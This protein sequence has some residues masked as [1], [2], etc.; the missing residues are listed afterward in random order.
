[1]WEAL[2]LHQRLSLEPKCSS[3]RLILMRGSIMAGSR[4]RWKWIPHFV[5]MARTELA[6]V[7]ICFP[8][9][10]M[11]LITNCHM[12]NWKFDFIQVSNILCPQL[13]FFHL[14][15]CSVLLHFGDGRMQA[16]WGFSSWSGG[17]ILEDEIFNSLGF[18]CP[19]VGSYFHSLTFWADC[20]H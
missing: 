17:L 15:T 13:S 16:I 5:S 12:N 4:A 7:A 18:F 1:M 2:T 14:Q 10:I 20:S 11:L 8:K 3:C 6:A 19:K 9:E